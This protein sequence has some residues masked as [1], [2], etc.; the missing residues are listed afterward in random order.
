MGRVERVEIVCTEPFHDETVTV[1]RAS[2]FAEGGGAWFFDGASQGLRVDDGPP[3]D[4]L[5]PGS[6]VQYRRRYVWECSC[7]LNATMTSDVALDLIDRLRRAGITEIGLR[8]VAAL[9]SK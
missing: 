1:A 7:G 4:R 6:D 3:L 5:L 9:L 8:R 2:W